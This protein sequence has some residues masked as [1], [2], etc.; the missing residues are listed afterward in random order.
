MASRGIIPA[1]S[2]S[3]SEA[4]H[5]PPY[6]WM[7]ETGGQHEPQADILETTALFTGAFYSLFARKGAREGSNGNYDIPATRRSS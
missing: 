4:P 6:L 5:A 7:F 2:L 1:F 3:E